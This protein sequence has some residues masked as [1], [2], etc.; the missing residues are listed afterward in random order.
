[1]KKDLIQEIANKTGFKKTSLQ[2]TLSRIKKRLDLKSIEQAACYYI[3]K[4]RVDINVSSI[5]DDVTRVVV[6]STLSTRIN[7]SLSTTPTSSIKQKQLPAPRIRWL[8]KTH[9]I[10]AE[11]LSSFY[12]YLFL[13]ENALRLEISNILKKKDSNWW[14]S[15][16][17]IDLPEVYRYSADERKRQGKLSMIGNLSALSPIDLVTLGHLENIVTKYKSDFVPAVFPNLQFFTGHMV[18]VKR[19]RNAIAHMAPST[20]SKDIRNAKNE[21]DILLQYLST[22]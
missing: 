3:K 4:N 20:T 5:M 7:A 1:M 22:K 21:I 8:P 2:T 10:L 15:M 6:R 11:K 16:I 9:Y 12:G 18:I 13:F 17:K 14:E 19:V